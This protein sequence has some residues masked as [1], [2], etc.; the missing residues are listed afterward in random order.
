MVDSLFVH[1]LGSNCQEDNDTF[2]LTLTSVTSDY[3]NKDMQ[4]DDTDSA[5]VT[6][7]TEK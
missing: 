4:T 5:A 7:E 2:L 3:N 6:D 1:S